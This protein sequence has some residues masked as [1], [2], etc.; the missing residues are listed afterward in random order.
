MYRFQ[1][2]RASVLVPVDFWL[3][4]A[5]FHQ[6]VGFSDK[7]IAYQG[8]FCVVMLL[9]RRVQPQHRWEKLNEKIR[10][11]L[12][13]CNTLF[14]RF[15]V[16]HCIAKLDWSGNAIVATS[17]S[18]LTVYHLHIPEILLLTCYWCKTQHGCVW[19]QGWTHE[20]PE[21]WGSNQKLTNVYDTWDL[22]GWTSSFDMQCIIVCTLSIMM[23]R[24]SRNLKQLTQ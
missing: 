18:S 23:D 13:A 5:F 11:K 22:N 17:I 20:S 16:W 19:L 9:A 2:Y 24:Q 10:K 7:I 12:W 8:L 15:L 14:G 6:L 1:Q 21:A 4:G 3:H